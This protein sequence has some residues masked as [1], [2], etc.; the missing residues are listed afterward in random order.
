MDEQ[1]NLPSESDNSPTEQPPEINPNSI[2]W[3]ASEFVDNAKNFG[4]YLMFVVAI[5]VICVAVYIFTHSIFSSLVIFVLG[6]ALCFMAG[7]RPRELEY[8]LDNQGI[9]IN[10]VDHQFSEFKAY[11]LVSEGGLDHI[12]LISV[13]RFTPNK[14]IY[15][16]PQD[17]D[18][19]ISL[20]GEFLPL[21][22]SSKDPIDGFMKRI[23]L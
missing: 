21:Q 5:L 11:A 18:R 13:R 6:L 1:P 2:T 9:V 22:P 17:R 19:I 4:W 14:T 20:L 10:N 7:R 12:S 23:G 8:G 15:F 3:T 16:E